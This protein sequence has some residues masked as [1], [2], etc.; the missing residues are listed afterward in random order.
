MSARLNTASVAMQGLFCVLHFLV[1]YL[2]YMISTMAKRIT[3]TFQADATLMQRIGA[4]VEL[5]NERRINSTDYSLPWM[6]RSLLIRKALEEY[7]T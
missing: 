1:L 7:L 3:I 6:T 2:S 4:R 5:D